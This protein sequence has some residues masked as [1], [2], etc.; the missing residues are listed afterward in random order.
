[1]EGSNVTISE[2][3][4]ERNSGESG[5]GIFIKNSNV[6]ITSSL[7]IENMANTFGGAIVSENATRILTY[8]HGI[9]YI[10]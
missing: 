7:F 8:L 9:F 3:I 6:N 2:S 4:F 5:G 10:L 1:M